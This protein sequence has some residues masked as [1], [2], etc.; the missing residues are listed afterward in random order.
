[1]NETGLVYHGYRKKPTGLSV[2]RRDRDGNI[3]ELDPRYDLRNHSPDGFE[4]GYS[5]SGPAQ[6]ALALCAD[7]LGNDPAALIVYQT[8]K[9]AVI[10]RLNK[11][12]WAMS[13]REIQLAITTLLS[14]DEKLAERVRAVSNKP[15][16]IA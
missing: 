9:Q 10:V 11:K 4:W 16:Q 3:T 5:G 12:A 8:F 1:M 13:R 14:L 2:Y 6:L 15:A 7:A